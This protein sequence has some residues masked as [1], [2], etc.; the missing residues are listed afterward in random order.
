VLKPRHDHPVSEHPPD[1]PR[2][3]RLDPACRLR[4][5]ED[6]PPFRMEPER[7]RQVRAVGAVER[8]WPVDVVVPVGVQVALLEQVVGGEP[9]DASVHAVEVG[10]PPEVVADDLVGVHGAERSAIVVDLRSS[11]YAG[12]L[13]ADRVLRAASESFEVVVEEEVVA[14]LVEPLDVAPVVRHP[15]GERAEPRDDHQL[16][17]HAAWALFSE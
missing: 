5:L 11:P 1:Q 10:V 17:D 3:G 4:L 9:F 8:P 7:E 6:L 13:D 16:P 12:E 15:F 2:V 14:V